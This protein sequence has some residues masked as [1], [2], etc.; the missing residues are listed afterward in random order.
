LRRGSSDATGEAPRTRAIAVLPFETLAGDAAD[1]LLEVTLPDELVG[2]LSRS[3]ELAVRPFSASRGLSPDTG[4]AEA[5]QR[6]G[7]DLLMTG[8]LLL[9]DGTLRVGLQAVD[10]ADQR[11]VWRD[12]LDLP[13][14]DL[15]AQRQR[16]EDSVRV[17]LLP[18]A[19]C[20]RS[21]AG[22]AA[23]ELRGLPPLPRGAC[24]AG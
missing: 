7:A 21:G 16:L 12:S 11:V 3:R 23:G 24:G 15:L 18:R 1:P 2:V 13:P 22:N 9:R 4:V 8:S 10:V 6:L 20:C 14:A 5:A 19:R 17:G